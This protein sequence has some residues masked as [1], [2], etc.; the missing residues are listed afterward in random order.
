MSIATEIQRLQEAKA[1][2]KAAIE[3]KGVEVGNGLID[4]YA[5]KVDAVYDKGVTDGKKS[6]YDKFWDNFQQNGKLKGYPCA[7]QKWDES[8]F[9]PKYDIIVGANNGTVYGATASMFNEFNSKLV[10][11]VETKEPIDLAQRLEDCGVILDTSRADSFTYTFHSANVTRIPPIDT[12]GSSS[13]GYMAFFNSNN[14]ETID[15]LIL[16]EDGSQSGNSN[17]FEG[18]LNLKNITIE[19]VIGKT[20]NI[21]WSTLLTKASIKSI[22]NA[23]SDKQGA[24]L[25]LSKTAVNREF[26]SDTSDK[27]IETIA[28]KVSSYNGVTYDGLWT[29]SLV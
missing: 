9:Y 15:K 5:D 11:K 6:Q 18:C 22:V 7:F 1:D 12:R 13:I 20:F 3:E 8:A 27:W 24:S 4:G 26:G 25:I 28:D 19:G 17:N 2:I 29:I 21:R 10:D 16:K 23:L 14:L